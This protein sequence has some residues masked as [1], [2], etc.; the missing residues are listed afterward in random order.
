MAYSTQAD[1]QE[2]LPEAILID[3]TD[4]AGAGSVDEAVVTRAIADADAEI[5]GYCGTCN[6]VPFSP[7][8]DLIRSHSVTIAIYNLYA[9]RDL[10][11]SETRRKRYDDA[12]RFLR[13]VSNG[14]VTLGSDAPDVSGDSGPEA[15][16]RVSDRVFS[17]GRAS[18]GSVGSLDNF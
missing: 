12:V 16:T 14:V 5:D 9:R 13:D 3:L 6:E 11:L 1:I 4:D 17:R 15:T 8:P 18:D 7:V 10:G 2:Q